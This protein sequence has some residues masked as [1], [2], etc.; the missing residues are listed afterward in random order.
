MKKTI[1]ALAVIALV[2]PLAF[3]QEVL[4]RNAV[5]YVKIDFRKGLN[6]VTHQFDIMVG[7][8]GVSNL[9]PIAD[10]PSGTIIQRWDYVNQVYASSE[11]KV[12]FPSTRWSPGTNTFEIGESMWVRIPSGA[13]SNSYVSYLMGEVPV[14]SKSTP[15]GGLTFSGV[16]YPVAVSISGLNSSLSY[17]LKSGDIVQ[18]W[19]ATVTNYVQETYVTFPSVRW[20]PGTMTINPGE[21]IIIRRT[22]STSQTN[23]VQNKPYTW[24]E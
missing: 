18:K 16:G 2:A 11:T 14:A 1:I 23:W 4:S 21:G 13:S 15:L 17:P 10:F 8:R 5:G 7:D 3:G 24:P 6:L 12:T 9:F 19:D 22:G 20:N